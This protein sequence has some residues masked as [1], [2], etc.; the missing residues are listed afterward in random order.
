MNFVFHPEARAD[1][2]DARAW[3]ESKQKGLG[4]DFVS[5]VD[6]SLR[7]ISEHPRAFPLLLND[8]RRARLKRFVVYSII[9]EKISDQTI[10]IYSVF[11]GHRSPKV[12]RSRR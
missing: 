9:F 12:W 7:R 2:L 1:L 6:A 5:E 8:M 4:D 11:H 10:F 3:Y